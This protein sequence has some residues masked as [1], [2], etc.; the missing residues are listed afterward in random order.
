MAG[1][2]SAGSSEAE[3]AKILLA[4][5]IKGPDFPHLEDPPDLQHHT[6]LVFA[7]WLFFFPPITTAWIISL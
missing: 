4:G 1:E 7:S 6:H 3:S 2:D 5:P